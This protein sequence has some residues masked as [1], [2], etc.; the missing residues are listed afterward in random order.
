MLLQLKP[1]EVPYGKTYVMHVELYP[2]NIKLNNKYAHNNTSLLWV[3]AAMLLTCGGCCTGPRQ[4]SRLHLLQLSSIS[5][6]QN[7]I[8][9]MAQ[10]TRCCIQLEPPDVSIYFYIDICYYVR[11]DRTLYLFSPSWRNGQ[12]FWPR[13]IVCI[14][15]YMYISAVKRLQYLIAINRINVTVNSRLIAN[16]FSMLNPLIS[17]SH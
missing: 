15:V 6:K 4:D 10:A 12:Q 5:Y 11:L 2:V 8:I 7:I 9:A 16:L 13:V 1:Q 3:T 17:L 14:C